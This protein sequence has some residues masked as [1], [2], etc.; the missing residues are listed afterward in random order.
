MNSRPRLLLS[1]AANRLQGIRVFAA[2]LNFDDLI[3]TRVFPSRGLPRF[4]ANAMRTLSCCKTIPGCLIPSGLEATIA[5]R[6]GSRLI[7]RSTFSSLRA[8]CSAVIL[9]PPP[10]GPGNGPAIRGR[11]HFLRARLMRR[12]GGSAC[13]SLRTLGTTI[14]GVMTSVG[15]HPFRGGSSVQGSHVG[16][17]RGCSGPH[18]GRLPNRDCAL[19]S[20]GCF[21]GIPSGCRLRCSTRCCSMLCACG[22]GPTVLGTAVARVQ[23]YSRCGQLVYHRPESCHSFPLCVASSGRVPPRRL[24]CGRI[25]TRSKTC[26]EQ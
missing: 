2:A 19:Y 17:F 14:G 26:C 10:E 5:E 8:F 12:L 18:V 13:V 16:K 3:C 21:L 25:G 11:I 9:P 7:L 4:V 23:V 24:C 20:C 15:R 22:K 6:D 1:A